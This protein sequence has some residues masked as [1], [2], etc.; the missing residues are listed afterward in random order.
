MRVYGLQFTSDSVHRITEILDKEPSISRRSLARRVCEWMKWKSISGRFKDAVCRKALSVLDKE[1]IIVLPPSDCRANRAKPPSRAKKAALVQSAVIACDLSGV[2]PIEIKMV[3]SRY[4]KEAKVWKALMDAHHY[5]GSGPLCG[6]Q[7]R[8][9]IHSPLHGYLGGLSFSS[10]AWALAARDKYIGWT[11]GARRAHLQRVVCNS[12]F[13]IV[14]TVQ[15]PNLASHILSRCIGRI[16]SD[17]KTCYGVEPVLLE[18]FIDPQQYTGASY[19][20]ANWLY[21]GK[22]SGRRSKQRQDSGGRKDIYL[23]PL[24]AEWRHILCVKP[25]VCLGQRPRPADPA[26]W[27]EEE[28]GT[29]GFYDARLKR[30]LFSLV[31]DFYQQVEAPIPQ[32]CGSYAKT[33]GAYRFFN[34]DRVTMDTMLYAHTESTIER[35]KNYKVVLA[36]Q[37][38]STLNYTTHRATEGLGPISNQRDGSVGLVVH[39]TMGFTTEG[40]PLGLLDV[41]C[42]ARDR[43]DIGKKHRRKKLPIDQKESVKWLKSYQAVAEVQK[44]CPETML[45]SVGDRESDIYELFL[46]ATNNRVG[47]HLLVR[48]E[49]SRNRKAGEHYL[50]EEMAR[51]PVAG[52]HGVHI[53]RRGC[54]LARDAK[55]QVRHAKVTLQP[56]QDKDY[57]SIDVWMVYAREIDSP[58]SVKSPLEWMLL[59][60][61]EVNNL[62]QA[63]ERLGWYAKR[64]GIEVYH[65]TLKSGCRIEDRRLESAES[66]EAC[67]AI[68]MVLAWRIYHLT[69]LSREIPDAA[70]TVFF[71]EAEWKALYIFINNSPNLPDKEPTLREITRMVGSLGG[72]LGRKSDGEPGTTS[73]WRGLQ[74][75]EDITATYLALLPHLRAGP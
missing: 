71:E 66:L 40:T 37:D 18:T 74:R 72:F 10:P 58:A 70:C 11:E 1:G 68:D 25:Q 4:S 44:L 13:L 24:C 52:I 28:F 64:W 43:Q 35:I 42:W 75:L 62:E 8:Y 36:V 56:P 33:K 57:R 34:N 69:K 7:I 61:V 48:C 21:V 45:V 65:R 49:R 63:C 31:R 47:P 30:R 14:P 39:D 67:L 54:Q 27:V 9:L 51:Q 5:L 23:Y 41:Q 20:A 17:W 12:R 19:R 26:D 3:T 59:T 38:T 50:W 16:A 53:P 2:G 73:L 6:A 32:A 60:T 55:L 15:V 46:E 29:V 22:T